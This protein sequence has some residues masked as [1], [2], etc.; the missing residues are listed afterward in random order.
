MCAPPKP[1]FPSKDAFSGPTNVELSRHCVFLKGIVQPSRPS[2][3]P[4]V[5][6]VSDLPLPLE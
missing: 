4:P 3:A 5:N 2:S 1:S 6:R